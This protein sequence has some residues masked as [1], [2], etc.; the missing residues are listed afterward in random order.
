MKLL[1]IIPKVEQGQKIILA[2]DGLSRSGKTTFVRNIEQ[3]MREKNNSIYIFYHCLHISKL[4]L[5]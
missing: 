5:F 1:K 4:T 3:H 2:I